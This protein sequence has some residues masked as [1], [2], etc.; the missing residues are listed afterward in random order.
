ME[1]LSLELTKKLYLRFCTIWGEKFVKPYHTEEFTKVWW[2]DWSEG[3]AGIKPENIKD[4]LTHCKMELEWPPSLAEFRKICE[5]SSGM[6]SL[7]DAFSSAIRKDFTHPVIHL[8]WAR[9]GSWAMSHDKEESLR[10]RFKAAYEQAVGEYRADP[11]RAMLMLEKATTVQP[12]LEQAKP[13]SSGECLSFKER[14]EQWNKAALAEMERKKDEEGVVH[15]IWDKNLYA[16]GSRSFDP[17]YFDDRRAYLISVTEDES[18]T[19]EH[20]DKYDRIRYLREDEG[21]AFLRAIGNSGGKGGAN[22]QGKEEIPTKGKF[23]GTKTVYN[24]WMSD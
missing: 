17:R 24:N 15:P 16:I 7:E 12:R 1:N 21:T 9:V 22:P 8:A 23:K 3:M 20:E 5:R 2:D 19:L 6:P 4:G 14:Y 13:L 10:P 18:V 11:E